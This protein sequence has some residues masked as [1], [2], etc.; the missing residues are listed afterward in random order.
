MAQTDRSL[1]ALLHARAR[2]NGLPLS[3]TFEL[4]P[5]CNLS[6]KMCYVRRTPEEVRTHPRPILSLEQW[7][8]IGGEALDAGMLFLLLTGGEPFLWPHFRELYEYLHRKGAVIS[9]NTNGT[10]LTEE[11][12]SWLK[13]QPPA[14]VNV[15]LYGASEAAYGRLCGCESAYGQVVDGIERLQKA[16]ILVK[17]NASM[18]PR[19]ADD[20]EGIIRFAKERDLLLDIGTYMF[21]PVRREAESFGGGE[22][23]TPGEAAHYAVERMR[24]SLEPEAY[25]HYLEQAL[26]GTVPAP[27][28]DESCT[29]PA[30]GQVKCSAGRSSFWITWDG[31]M[32]PCGMVPEPKVDVARTGFGEAWRQIIAHT[33]K[34]RLSGVCDSCPDKHVCHS[35]MAAAFSET[36]K[37]SGIPTYLC[38]MAEEIRT[39]AKRA[40]EELSGT[41]SA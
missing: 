30:D 1:T 2:Q 16:G 23:F 40:L 5:V 33:E 35:C 17:L 13:D 34:I 41:A 12:V 31:Y 37:H 38:Q 28:L 27:G 7:K 21:S 19:N 36:G 32:L 10:L 22:R 20:M 6:C 15:T 9:V 3:G 25:R 8:R 14:R 39:R 18:T 24:L 11:T 29:D 26:R 4:T